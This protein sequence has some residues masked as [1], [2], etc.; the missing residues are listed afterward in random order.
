MS[1]P[2]IAT[3]KAHKGV[4]GDR[5]AARDERDLVETERDKKKVC[6]GEKEEE[7]GGED[8]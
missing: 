3:H 4:N 7:G 8:K 1:N 5:I 6:E 2:Q